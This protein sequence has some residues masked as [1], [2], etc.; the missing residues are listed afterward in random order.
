M[1]KKSCIICSTG[2]SGST[3]LTTTLAGLNSV[4]YAAEYFHWKR[5]PK[6]AEDNAQVFQDYLDEIKKEGTSSNGIF[7]IKMHWG[8]LQKL[9]EMA[10]KH[11][12]LNTEKDV[13]I[14]RLLF[15]NP[16]YV[17]I[18]RNDLV[19]QAISL[20]IA[21]QTQVFNS[22][23]LSDSN[24]KNAKNVLT[25]TQKINLN[26]KQLIFNPFSIYILK[27]NIRQ[28][29]KQWL[30]FLNSNKIKYYEVIYEKF[31]E[32]NV[33]IKKTII[34]IVNFLEINKLSEQ[35]E[36]KIPLIKVSTPR[37]ERWYDYYNRIPEKLLFW[38]NSIK[39]KFTM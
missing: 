7:A 22:L 25:S 5:I 2:R 27:E 10:R 3:L 19:K 26:D 30:N 17:R 33:S 13:E 38:G 21:R 4:G 35:N 16:Y 32:S 34:N 15:P 11:L 39:N 9:L 36:I 6:L 8:Q 1:I 12:S 20:E 28:E 37:N 24:D 31:T 18:H 14:I 29:N 23:Q